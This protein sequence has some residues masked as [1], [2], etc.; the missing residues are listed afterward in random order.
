MS[1]EIKNWA[2]S[3]LERFVISICSAAVAFSSWFIWQQQQTNQKLTSMLDQIAKNDARQDQAI[4]EIKAQMVGWDTL[5][6][7]ERSLGMMAAMNK[8]ND[9]MGAVAEVLKTERESR[10]K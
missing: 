8:G 2:L 6:R 10:N 9:A 4:S 1:E 3:R 7:I 5:T